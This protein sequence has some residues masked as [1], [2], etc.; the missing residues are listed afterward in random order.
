[1][2]GPNW[3]TSVLSESPVDSPEGPPREGASLMY[4]GKQSN[5]YE[6]VIYMVRQYEINCGRIGAVAEQEQVAID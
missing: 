2:A 4:Y 5:K 3:S 6:C 1:M